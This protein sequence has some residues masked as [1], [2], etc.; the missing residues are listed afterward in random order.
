MSIGFDHKF[1]MLAKDFRQAEAVR[2]RSPGEAQLIEIAQFRLVERFG[3][4]AI[5]AYE[6]DALALDGLQELIDFHT[7][8]EPRVTTKRVAVRARCP[9]N[10]AYDIVG[11]HQVEFANTKPP[12]VSPLRSGGIMPAIGIIDASATMGMERFAVASEVL[13]E[14]ISDTQ[15]EA[16]SNGQPEQEHAI[17]KA[18]AGATSRPNQADTATYL[19]RD[20]GAVFEV[21]FNSTTTRTIGKNV[22][23]KTL[24]RLVKN[25]HSSRR[26]TL[27]ELVGGEPGTIS[28]TTAPEVAID[29][30][31]VERLREEAK[32]LAGEVA[33]AR[34]RGDHEKENELLGKMKQIEDF[35]NSN[36]WPSANGPKSKHINTSGAMRLKKTIDERLRR[37]LKEFRDAGQT[38]AAAHFKK[39]ITNDGKGS[40]GPAYIPDDRF[41]DWEF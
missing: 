5:E 20:T 35:I 8:E 38:E 31:G 1:R 34:S 32:D 29:H 3:E 25:R 21:R 24:Y 13:A 10:L 40:D 17:T 33:E 18:D 12:A 41:P 28:E 11:G 27:A 37:A 23:T 9:T 7:S 6:A 26:F 2:P 4:I 30:K 15:N 19:F 14:L 22:N 16:G 39:H 36:S